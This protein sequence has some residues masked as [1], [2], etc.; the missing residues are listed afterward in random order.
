MPEAHQQLTLVGRRSS[1]FT[2][3]PFIYAHELA[4][5]MAYEPLRG[6]GSQD[7]ANFAGNPALKMPVLR[8]GNEVVYGAQNICRVITEQARARGATPRMVWPEDL[9]DAT[10]RNAHELLAN[11]LAAQ[12]QLVMGTQLG[13]LPAEHPFFTKIR[14]G[15]EQSL[16]WLDAHLDAVLDAMPLSRTLS[17]FE[18]ALLCMVD[19]LRSVRPTLPVEGYARLVTFADSYGQRPAAQQTVFRFD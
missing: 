8:I 12:V 5:P 17:F 4:V 7:A 15:Y 11:V 6:L 1:L 13:D 19:H 2:R 9:R 3:M 16:A 18:V 10:S 14:A